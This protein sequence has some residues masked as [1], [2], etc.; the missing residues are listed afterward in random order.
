MNLNDMLA[1][2][3]IDPAKVLVLR[4]CPFEPQLRKVLPWLASEKPDVFNAYQQTQ[5]ARLEAVM[6]SLENV[7]H[8]ASFIG[9]E[10]GKAHFAGLYRIGS[11]RAMTMTRYWKVPAYLEMKAFGMRGFTGDRPAVRWFDLQ[12]TKFYSTWHGKLVVGWPKPEISWWRRAHR[13]EFPVVAVLEEN[14]FHEE[15]PEWSAIDLTWKELAVIPQRWQAALAE[16]RGV[17]YIFDTEARLGYVGSA[18]GKENIFGRWKNYAASGHGG[19]KLLRKLDPLNL[20]FTILQRV[21][22]DM[23]AKDIIV[24][25]QSWKR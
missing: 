25:E 21:S 13:N 22:P 5:G 15:M 3:G 7:G 23:D 1:G 24:I 14:S 2:K 12:I 17:Y 11:S 6:Q 20:R 16:W 18:Y 10:P 4:H 8:V 19:N 9:V